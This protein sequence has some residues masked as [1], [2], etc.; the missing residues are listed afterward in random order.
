LHPIFTVCIFILSLGSGY[1]W[2]ERNYK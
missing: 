2:K 1:K